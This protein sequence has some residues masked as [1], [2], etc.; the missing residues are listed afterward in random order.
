[1]A[2]AL[3]SLAETDVRNPIPASVL[4]AAL[5]TPPFVVVPGTFNTRD[6]GLLIAGDDGHGPP[7]AGASIRPGFI[8]RTG[9]LEALARSADGQA[10]LRDTLRIRRIFD[11]R[12]R[13][14]HAKSPDPALDGI[15]GVWLGD[16]V[17]GAEDNPMLNVGL[18]A[19]GDG[20]KGYAH[21]YM[22]VLDKYRAS[23]REVLT[24]VRDRPADPIMFHCTAGRD[25]TGVLAGLL[26]TLAGYDPQTVQTDFLLS[27][28]GTEVAREHLLAFAVKYS[29]GAEGGDDGSGAFDEVP[30]FYNLVSLKG[31]CWDAFA[32]AVRS[33]YGGFEGYATKELGF[34]KH[35][36]ATI[37]KNLNE[38]PA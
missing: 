1:M 6:L 38:A 27:R 31:A 11:L 10:V 5:Q 3:R 16:G 32:E 15:E 20:E 18:F 12:S 13:E 23:F 8:F 4:L 28:I 22:D 17:D 2:T 30:G 35:D 34:S 33:Q 19:D 14:E 25:R 21:M 29:Q 9:G 26:E 7:A 24:S 37:K 36:L